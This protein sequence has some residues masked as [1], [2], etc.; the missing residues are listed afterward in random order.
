[1][2]LVAYQAGVDQSNPLTTHAV[3][4][5]GGDINQGRFVFYNH[6]AAQCTRCHKGQRGRKGGIAGPD[7]WNVGSLHGRDYLLES[8]VKPNAHIAPGYGMVSVTLKD[9]TIAAG[10][11]HKEDSK[12]VIIADI[13]TGEKTSYAREEIEEMTRPASTMPPMSGILK[14]S[15]IRDLIAYLASLKD[16]K[17]KQ[18]K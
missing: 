12:K 5:K 15:E 16:P 7:L 4:L 3:T 1:A 6:G 18:K 13:T 10:N 14:K 9:N 11:L 8:L 2:A 17:K